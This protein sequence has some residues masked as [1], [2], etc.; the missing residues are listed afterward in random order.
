MIDFAGWLMPVQYSGIVD[1]HHTVRQAAG[2]F[3]L[4]HMGQVV[5]DGPDA[6]EYL[7]YITTNDVSRLGPGDAQYSMMLYPHGGVIDD[8][9]VYRRPSESGYFVVINAANIDKDVSWMLDQATNRDDLSVHVR[10]VSDEFGMIAL[11]G[12]KAEE[13]M[14]DISSVRLDDMDS[15]SCRNTT[16]AGIECLAARTGYTGEDGWEFYCPIADVGALWDSIMEAGSDHG[17]QADRS[18]SAGYITSRSANAAL[19]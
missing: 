18:R 11:Q 19:R 6:L 15:F 14:R 10:R 4:G 3:D 8:I 13:I 16:V 17:N 12:P 7:Q 5:V 9:I 2:L 1:E